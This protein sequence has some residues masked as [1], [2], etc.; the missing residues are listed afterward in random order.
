MRNGTSSG[1]CSEQRHHVDEVD[2]WGAD[3]RGIAA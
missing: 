1:A 3:L 2:M